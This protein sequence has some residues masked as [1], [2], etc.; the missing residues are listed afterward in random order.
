[1]LPILH[2]FM[3]L[4]RTPVAQP[5]SCCSSGLNGV[6]ARESGGR[7]GGGRGEETNKI[8]MKSIPGSPCART[9]G[10]SLGP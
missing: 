3:V 5:L 8:H 6:S 9:Q 7:G 4:A 2:V 1:M 10:I